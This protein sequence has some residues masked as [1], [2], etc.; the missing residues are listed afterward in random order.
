[1]KRI[2]LVTLILSCSSDP[3]GVRDIEPSETRM[4][5]RPAELRPA[6]E[7]TFSMSFLS[8]FTLERT[9]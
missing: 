7:C 6:R 3:A 9:R 5:M 1:M 4:V 2:L 8:G